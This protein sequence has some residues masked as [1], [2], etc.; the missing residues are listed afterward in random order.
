MLIKMHMYEASNGVY[1][2]KH[3][4]DASPVQSGLKQGNVL[5]P[6]LF[7]VYLHYTIKKAQENCERA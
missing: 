4:S 3:L 5:S 1:V 2:G 7:N 6:L